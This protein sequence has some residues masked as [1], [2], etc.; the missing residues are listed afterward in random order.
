MQAPERIHPSQAGKARHVR[1]GRMGLRL[2]LDRQRGQVRVRRR[3]AAGSSP[4]DELEQDVRMTRAG[5]DDDRIGS[6]EPDSYT[7]AGPKRV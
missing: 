1:V 5:M 3:I 2:M 6:G 4:L 7:S